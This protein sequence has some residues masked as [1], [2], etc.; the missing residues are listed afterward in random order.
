MVSNL[1]VPSVQFGK[2]AWTFASRAVQQS[3]TIRTIFDDLPGSQA[4][5]RPRQRNR[6]A[7]A[8]NQINGR[9]TAVQRNLFLTVL[10]LRCFNQIRST[11]DCCADFAESQGSA[12]D[13]SGSLDNHTPPCVYLLHNLAFDFSDDGFKRCPWNQPWHFLLNGINID[14][15]YPTRMGNACFR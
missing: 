3:N 12:S 14:K 5:R 2:V 6:N 15:S 1:V 4:R 9:V 10:S 13:F 7:P 8:H 11:L